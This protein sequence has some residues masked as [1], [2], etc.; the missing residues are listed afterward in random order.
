M[1]EADALAVIPARGGSKRIPRKNVRSLSGRPLIAWAIDIAL[2]SGAFE[3]VVVS[4]DDDEIADVARSAGAEVPFIRPLALSD[5]YA[6]TGAV[7]SHAV[8]AMRQAGF[9]GDHVCCIYPG[10]VFVTGDDVSDARL[11]L[12]VEPRMDYVMAVVEYP[13]PVQRALRVDPT[14]IASPVSPEF[15]R[16]RTQ[17]LESFW[18]DAGQFYWGRGQAWVEDRPVHGNARA[19]RLRHSAVVDIDTEQDWAK[20]EW[21]HDAL[22]RQRSG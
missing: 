16:T 15:V 12:D 22:L 2:S 18:H 7:M 4:T 10:A 5:D 1:R 9:T 3:R 11:L 8:T 17:D 19:Y 14:G 6:T 20:A 13:H 21:M